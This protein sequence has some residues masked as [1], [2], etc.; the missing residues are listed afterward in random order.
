[1]KEKKKSS[2]LN[3]KTGVI[4]AVI[5]IAGIYV[6]SDMFSN[7]STDVTYIA[8]QTMIDKDSLYLDSPTSVTMKLPAVNMNNTGVTAFL[9]VDVR[10]GTGLVL[11]NVNNII[12]N[13]DTQA[14]MRN[15]AE[16]ASDYTNK[17]LDDVDVIYNLV[18]NASILEGPSAGAAFTIATVL[19]LEDEK[20]RDDVMITG[21]INHDFTIGPAGRVKAKALAA[22]EAGADLFLVSVGESYEY[23]E[24]EYCSDYGLFEGYC[25]IEY[26]PVKIEDIAEI[27]V[28]E[29]HTLDDAVALF[30]A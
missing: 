28:V 29:V 2:K 17:N 4:M 24:T 30:R 20:I 12:S 5:F 1:M 6:G 23:N 22:K 13:Y 21:M 27:R 18:A 10:P 26:V 3:I 9:E 11:V 7:I 16:I 15:A 19:A 14:S 8:Q 25:Q